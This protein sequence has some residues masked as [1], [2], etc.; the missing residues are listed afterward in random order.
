[1]AATDVFSFGGDR[2][3]RLTVTVPSGVTNG[4]LSVITDGG[5][6]ATFVPPRVDSSPTVAEFGT[7]ANPAAALANVFQII[8]LHGTGLSAST[9]VIFPTISASGVRGNTTMTP[10]SASADGTT[11]TVFVPPFATTGNVSIE[12]VGSFL[13]QIVPTVNGIFIEPP[14]TYQPGTAITVFGRGFQEGGTIVRFPGTSAPVSA[15]DITGQNDQFTIVVPAGATAG[16]LTVSTEGGTSNTL[17]LRSPTLVSVTAAADQGSPQDPGQPSAN[18]NQPISVTGTDF[19]DTTLITF[20][21]FDFS[22]APVL[23]TVGGTASPDGTSLA[24]SVPFAA[25]SGPVGVLDRDTR[26][27]TGSVPFQVVP[28]VTAVSGSFDPG[29]QATIM[30][31]GFDPAGTQVQFPGVPDPVS[32]DP[33]SILD[34]SGQQA[35]VTVPAGVDTGG[36]LTVLTAGGVSN[37]IG[38]SGGN[39]REVEPNN[40]PAIANTLVFH[41]AGGSGGLSA[42][43]LATIDPPGDLN[44]FGFDGQGGHEIEVR[45]VTGDPPGPTLS[46]RVTWLDQDGT[47]V[48]DSGEGP[49]GGENGDSFSLFLTIPSSGTYFLL[50]EE[51]SGQGGPSDTYGIVVTDLSTFPH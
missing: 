1:V 28:T 42:S 5:T 47:T 51:T 7:P 37:P 29:S 31:L 48:L 24:V 38:L 26:L 6:S 40:S 23:L 14:G 36:D 44:V 35:T 21:S 50:V 16:L 8:E 19:G 34:S 9:Q 4:T 49:V 30:G 3:N 11:A 2:N 18:I 10:L 12:G 39:D 45:L 32:A 46:L 43:K 20:R 13:L 17:P 41:A 15:G 33:Q 22:G 25:V 27:G